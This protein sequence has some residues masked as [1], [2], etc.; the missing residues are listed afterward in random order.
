MNFRTMSLQKIVLFLVLCAPAVAGAQSYPPV[1]SQDPGL[2]RKIKLIVGLAQPTGEFADNDIFSINSGYAHPGGVLGVEYDHEFV[3]HYGAAFSVLGQFH[4]QNEKEWKKEFPYFTY[5]TDSRQVF[6]AMIGPFF[7]TQASPDLVLF[8]LPQ[9]GVVYSNYPNIR[10][11]DYT[12][13]SL[14]FKAEWTTTIGYKASVG[15]MWGM[16]DFG[17]HLLYA[18]PEF[19]PQFTYRRQSGEFL[20]EKKPVRAFFFTAGLV[21]N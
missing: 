2:L 3:E 9:I 5:K 14:D 17:V 10:I 16:Y 6:S 11:T 8:A 13:Q 19:H 18:N 12:I 15:A 21:I 1:E 20:P 7:N 4:T